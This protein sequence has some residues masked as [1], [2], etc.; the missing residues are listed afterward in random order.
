MLPAPTTAELATFTG[1]DEAS[2]TAF[3][4]QALAQATLLFR[5]R[6]KLT[7][8]PADPDLE[9][10][11]RMA[12]LEMAYK[13]YLEQPHSE[14]L[15][16]PFSSETIGSYSYSK[17]ATFLNARQGKDTGLLWWEL[18]MDELAQA[19]AVIAQHGSVKIAD[20]LF[21]NLDTD[22]TWILGPRELYNQPTIP[23]MDP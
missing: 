13:L 5:L 23:G 6:T 17:S 16:S 12:I 4:A 10:L 14:V 21:I 22:E 20:D 3:A 9:Q 18:A 7:D 19:D 11:A 2:F 15:A 1:R 8:Y